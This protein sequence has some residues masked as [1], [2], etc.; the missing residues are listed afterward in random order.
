[1]AEAIA[2]LALASSIITVIDITRKVVTT[3]WQCY[4]GTG[5]A[6]KELVEVMSELMSLLGILDTLHSH[7]INLHDND[8]KNFLALE[9]LNRPDAVLAACAVVLQDVL[10]ILRVLQKRRLRS[11]IATATSSQ[12]FMTVKSRIERLKDLL[13]LALS[14]DHVTLSHAI[15]EYLQQAFGELQDKQH[16]IYCELLNIDNHITKLSRVSDEMTISQK[17]KHEASADRYYKTLCWLSA[18]D[19][20]ATHFNACKLQQHGTGLWLINGRDFPEWAGKDNSIFWL[21]AIPG[22]GKTIL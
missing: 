9:E 14:S 12:K 20:E 13:I 6:P 1:M 5:N 2:G 18:V 17:E 8:P 21:H 7:L 10:D 16:K 4:R 19:F 3:G 15:A 11:I 22:T